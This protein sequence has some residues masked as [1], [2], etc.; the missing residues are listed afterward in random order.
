MEEDNRGFRYPSINQNRCIECKKC[1]RSCPQNE[2]YER[3]TVLECFA[4][5]CRDIRLIS[6]A[7]SGGI[8]SAIATEFLKCG[9]AACGADMK[10]AENAFEVEHILVHEM[11][12]ISKLQG[13][14]YVQSHMDQVF[15]EIKRELDNGKRILFSGTPCQNAAIK[16][17]FENK[18]EQLFLI[19]IVCHG[20]PSQKFFNDYLR[21]AEKQ[22]GLPIEEYTFRDK[23]NGWKSLQ[24][25]FSIR[26][27]DGKITIIPNNSRDHS[28]YRL[29]LDG[30]I[31]RESCYACQYANTN[32]VGDLTI[33]DYWGIDRYNPELL[34]DNGG[35]L[36]IKQGISC[37]LVNTEKGKQLLTRYGHYLELYPVRLED[38]IQRNTQ[39]RQ[40]AKHSNIRE[41]VFNA[42]EKEGYD[43]VERVFQKYAIK[44]KNKQK[45]KK[46]V[47]RI[48][49]EQLKD[50]IIHHRPSH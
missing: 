40:P 34:A 10:K 9:G 20:T 15:L 43:G 49:P 8:F 42:Y 28:Y 1:I 18:L 45:L 37:I 31:Y 30:E 33:G 35:S 4:G 6:N 44:E 3:N 32:R 27:K 19:D 12:E 16:K 26:Q 2:P 36:D 38:V 50:F 14:K 39:L 23:E 47:K 22:V 5:Q 11:S 41:Q 13:S 48:L 24:G 25:H 7:S 46:A 17:V 29:F 21:Q